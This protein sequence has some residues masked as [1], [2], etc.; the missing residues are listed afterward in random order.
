MSTHCLRIGLTGGIGSGKST[1]AA[2]L[3]ERGATVI[4]ADALSRASTASQGAAIAAI[5]DTF[6]HALIDSE[7]ALDRDRMRSLVFQ[8]P[9]ARVRLEAIVHP[10][11]QAAMTEREQTARSAGCRM[12][13]LD[14]PLLI[15][16][17]RW[18]ST[19]DAVVVVDCTRAT[20]IRRV[21]QRNAMEV[22]QIEAIIASQ[23]SRLQRR[24]A[25]DAV[26]YNDGCTLQ[27]L[28]EAVA[29]LAKT[30]TL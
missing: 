5:A 29:A 19:L 7:G 27:E 28:G 24:R 26:V 14:I 3:A 8:D 9:T 23:A 15:E 11:V 20:Q 13:L 17:G 21:V 2:M 6:G 10:I 16:S 1:V 18:A 30:F 22:A 12:L 25:A 4:D